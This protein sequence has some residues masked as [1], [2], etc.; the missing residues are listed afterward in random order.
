MGFPARMTTLLNP[1]ALGVTGF[2]LGGLVHR[3]FTALSET[4]LALV[5]ATAAFLPAVA[6][7]VVQEHAVVGLKF[8]FRSWLRGCLSCLLVFMP[9]YLVIAIT[10]PLMPRQ[11]SPGAVLGLVFS[12]F[13]VW[14]CACDYNVLLAGKVGF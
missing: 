5:V 7:A 12:A 8:H 3:P 2:L 4:Q 9:H 6:V 14:L 13:L 1:V 11:F 10:C